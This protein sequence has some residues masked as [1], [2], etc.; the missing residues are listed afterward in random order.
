MA[1]MTAVILLLGM[2]MGL[3]LWSL[4][5][6]LWPVRPWNLSN[7]LAAELLDVSDVARAL[8]RSRVEDP[9]TVFGHLL[10]PGLHR[11]WRKMDALVGGRESQSLVFARSGRSESF[12]DF[13][14]HRIAMAMVGLAT[15]VLTGATIGLATDFPL[16]QSVLAGA[17]L[18]ALGGLWWSDYQLSVDVKR[19]EERMSEEFPTII[20]LL[21]LALAAGDSLPRAL[22]RV[23]KRA[24]GELGTEWSRMMAA[25]D[26]GAPLANSLRESALRVGGAHVTAF[27]E[28]LA[29]ALDRGAPLAEV[30]AAHARDAKEEY[31]RSLVDKAGK[32]EVQMLV[33]MVLL[34]LPV[35]VIFAIYPGLQALQFGF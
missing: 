12:G 9:I 6:A 10:S 31:T 27:V 28:H 13:R 19:R 32:A 7:R 35:T 26:V 2:L 18:G 5:G 29:Q 4:S 22:A 8:H 33:P 34:I 14:A 30:V 3:G 24:Q 17:L 1:G 23:S 16:P 15:G 11:L 20:E 21:G 25:V